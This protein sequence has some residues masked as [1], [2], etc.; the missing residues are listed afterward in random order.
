[1]M[2]RDE[3]DILTG[4]TERFDEMGWPDGPGR[5]RKEG[6]VKV[7]W[8][9]VNA[10]TRVPIPPQDDNPGHHDGMLVYPDP[11]SADAACVHQKAVFE[12][13]C[14]PCILGNEK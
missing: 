7:Y 12:V 9:I 14:L 4:K 1:M 13:D 3:W 10:I 11:R 8:V 6:E 2:T 5:A